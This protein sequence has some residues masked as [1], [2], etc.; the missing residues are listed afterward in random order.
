MGAFRILEQEEAED[1][2]KMLKGG[3]CVYGVKDLYKTEFM[4]TL[5]N[6][7]DDLHSYNKWMVMFKNKG[8]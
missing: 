1:V 3:V 6:D 8:E 5:I 7:F 2:E 4:A